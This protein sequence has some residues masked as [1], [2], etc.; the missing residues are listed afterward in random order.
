MVDDMSYA[1]KSQLSGIFCLVY[2][3]SFDSRIEFPCPAT[4]ECVRSFE[5]KQTEQARL[6]IRSK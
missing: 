2:Y 6:F 4:A 5:M 3:F 1:Y